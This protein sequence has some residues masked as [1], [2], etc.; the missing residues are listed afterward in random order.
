VLWSRPDGIVARLGDV[1][2]KMHAPDTDA[3]DLEARLRLAQSPQL[4]DVLCSALVAR[5]P[6]QWEG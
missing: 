2:V 4:R 5:N 3:R 1:V 6:H